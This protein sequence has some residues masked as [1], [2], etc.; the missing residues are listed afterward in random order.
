MKKKTKNIT[1]KP[2]KTPFLSA[3]KLPKKSFFVVAVMTSAIVLGT[4]TN[5]WGGAGRTSAQ[6]FESDFGNFLAFRH[7]I[8]T[9]NF[10]AVMRYAHRLKDIDAPRVQSQIAVSLFLAGN[11]GDSAAALSDDKNLSAQIAYYSYLASKGDWATLFRLS[12]QSDSV[13]L[14][15]FRIWSGVATR[16]WTLTLRFIDSMPHNDDWKHFKRGMVFAETNRPAQAR[17]QFSHVPADFLSLNDFL[18]MMTFLRENNFH[19]DA[20]FLMK[21]FTSGPGGAYIT[22][23]NIPSSFDEFRGPNN[24]F[25]FS[26]IQSVAHSPFIA[27]TSAALMLLRAAEQIGD[28]SENNDALNFYLGA[29]FFD[30]NEERFKKYFASIN[31]Q[32]AFAPHAMMRIAESLP[33]VRAQTR[34]LE[35]ILREYPLFM[36]ALAR[37][38]NMNLQNCDMRG[39]LR[40][41]NRALAAENMS[42]EQRG[43]L[44]KMRARIYRQSGRLENATDDAMRAMDILPNNPAILGEMARIWA[45]TGENLFEANTFA[46]SL[47][48]RFPTD[49]D[50]WVTLAMVVSANEGNDEALEI[51]TRVARVAEHNSLL[52]KLLGDAFMKDNN[53]IRASGA[54]QRAIELSGDGQTCLRDLRQ[55]LRRAM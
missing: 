35:R 37:L 18:Y 50:S 15:P 32:S 49:V 34:E 7:A 26:M 51:L 43:Y 10:D 13:L 52:F 23:D 40:I 25:A 8:H 36:P 47:I 46:N 14:S 54:Y 55:R 20:D 11:P 21:E 53:L 30:N 33:T 38:V 42:D 1:K 2:A 22:N 9:D 48:N 3:A 6:V 31:P 28:D 5:Q 44:F 19:D 24:A 29:H 16:H 27:S 39:S 17:E 12:R 41:V 45:L 4:I